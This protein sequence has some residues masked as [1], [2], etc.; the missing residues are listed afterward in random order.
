MNDPKRMDP[1]EFR[2]QFKALLRELPGGRVYDH[3]FFRIPSHVPPWYD[4][5]FDVCV[6]DRLTSFAIGGTELRGTPIRLAPFFQLWFRIG[7]N[8][9]IFRGTRDAHSFRAD[10]SGRLYLCSY[11]PGEWE[12]RTGGLRTPDSVYEGATGG[13]DVLL[14]RWACEPLEGLRALAEVGDVCGLV[15]TE[16][17]RMTSP[18]VP[19]PGWS[20]LWFVGPAEIYRPDD[21]PGRIGAI[22]CRTEADVGILQRDVSVPL[23]PG[24]RLRWSWR[25]DVLPSEVREDALTTHDYTSIAVEFENGQDLTYY[26]SSELPLETSFRC[27]IPTWTGRETHL[28]VRSGREGLGSW[29]DEDRDV[30]RDYAAAIGG[31][32]PSRIVRVWLIAVSFFQCREGRSRYSDIELLA[33]DERV[34]IS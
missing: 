19:P 9:E 24:T 22:G 10:R 13:L 8:G 14:V 21:A 26:W 7:E 16:I 33:G 15:A 17:D 23:A 2:S 18:I 3:D 32:M 20:Y 6:G 12:T 1:A 5:F 29:H 11:F 28:V 31:P 4:T 34:R 25:V 27:P 30:H